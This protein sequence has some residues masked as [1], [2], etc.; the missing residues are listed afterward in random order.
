MMDA[1]EQNIS[2]FIS[3]RL[4]EELPIFCEKC[5]YSLVGLSQHRC[6]QCEILQFTCPEC[7]HCQPINTLRPA[8][9]TFLG[10]L[11]GAWLAGTV[12][13]K[14]AFFCLTLLAWFIMGGEFAYQWNYNRATQTSTLLGRPMDFEA[15]VAYSVYGF[16]W[17]GVARMLLLRW[18]YGWKVGVVLALLMTGAQFLGVM[19]RRISDSGRS[20]GLTEVSLH[21]DFYLLIVIAACSIILSAGIA[22]VIWVGLVK[23][24]LPTRTGNA[25]MDWQRSLSQ[26]AS[27]LT[28]EPTPLAPETPATATT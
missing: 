2:K 1:A 23:A 22:W 15:V 20:S 19:T 11:R 18:H 17:A 3:P 27:V 26:K 21:S 7:G 4:G 16:F 28:R 12:F 24:F 10:R 8:F 13:V 5:G 6:A 9:Q 25:L 14:F